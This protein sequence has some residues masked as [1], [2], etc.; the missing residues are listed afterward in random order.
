MVSGEVIYRRLTEERGLEEVRVPFASLEELF[1]LV[2]T[3]RPPQLV[4]R[5]HISG[6]DEMSKHRLVSFVFRSIQTLSD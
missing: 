4:D 6:E 5:I 1:H 2:V 3:A